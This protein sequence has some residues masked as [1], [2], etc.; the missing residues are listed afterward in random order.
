M[1]R[2]L[3][4]LVRMIIRVKVIVISMAVGAGIAFALSMRQ[5][6]HT[7]G[8]DAADQARSLPGDDLVASPA[9]VET[10]SL[11]VDALPATIWPLLVAM[12][13]GRGGWYS[14]PILDRAW[15]TMGPR[16][17]GRSAETA[18]PTT[19]VE[20][21]RVP[22]QP[23]GGFV[24][25][26]VE[27]DRALV[28]FLDAAELREQ[29]EEQ[30]AEGS[31]EARQALDRMDEMPAFALS[32]AF[33]LEPEPGGRTRLIERVRLHM[34]VSGGQKRALPLMGLGLFAFVRRQMLGIKSRAEAGAG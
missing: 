12:G 24:A 26:V 27:A 18:P 4:F 33:V 14:Y 17:K 5:E 20:G 8:L 11:L 9:H 28:L 34:D 31:K 21:D 22:T 3:G 13:Y 19:L 1:L 32:W 16:A 7:W 10:R 29:V 6:S 30:A 15:S 23:G 2:L 25:R